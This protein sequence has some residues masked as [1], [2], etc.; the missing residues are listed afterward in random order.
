MSKETPIG[1]EPALAYEEALGVLRQ[2]RGAR[3]TRSSTAEYCELCSLELAHEHPHLVELASR[4]ILCACDACAL[5]F[6]GKERSK[7][8]RV[9]RDARYLPD[10]KM[11]DA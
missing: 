9:P 2:F 7:F 6:D 4:Q 5:L 10:F 8:K 3:R 1:H 11:T